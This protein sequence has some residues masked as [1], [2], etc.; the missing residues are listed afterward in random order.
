MEQLDL[1]DSGPFTPEEAA[2]R[3]KLASQQ[4]KWFT[5]CHPH[6]YTAHLHFELPTSYPVPPLDLPAGVR[7]TRLSKIQAE[8]KLKDG[9]AELTG[10]FHR[11][12]PRLSSL[13]YIDTHFEFLG[14]SPKDA[15]GIGYVW[16]WSKPGEALKIETHVYCASEQ[17]LPDARAV[18]QGLQA[19]KLKPQ[20][21]WKFVKSQKVGTSWIEV[22][23]ET[24]IESNAS[25]KLDDILSNIFSS[26]TLPAKGA[27]WAVDFEP[28]Y[29]RGSDDKGRTWC[30]PKPE[31]LR[32][33]RVTED[34]RQ[35][36]A[37]VNEA[38]FPGKNAIVEFEGTV[39][40]IE[41]FRAVFELCKRCKPWTPEA[42]GIFETDKGKQ[43]FLLYENT[44]KGI[45]LKVVYG[46]NGWE[47]VHEELRRNNG[48]LNV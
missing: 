43:G 39:E 45:K 14:W 6:W 7:F 37:L 10:P 18:Q 23:F 29:G 9:F 25:S 47:E 42:V 8:F 32:A 16:I 41:H 44:R 5:L 30:F 17:E 13:A 3:I 11:A 35:W 15:A 12:M 24:K 21:G 27:S 20:H 40:R 2:R 4:L 19:G 1:R 48:K 33:A 46:R 28:T 22:T 31:V 26:Q 34:Y 38:G 36:I